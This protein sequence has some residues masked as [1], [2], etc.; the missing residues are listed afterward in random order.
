MK[1][2]P[3]KNRSGITLIEIMIALV[4]I[5]VG[6]LGAM[7]YRYHSALDAR[8]ADVHVG[9]GRVALLLLE[10]WKG[11]AGNEDYDPRT[12][13]G[14]GASDISIY[15]ASKNGY[16]VELTGDPAGTKTFYYAR[17]IRHGL[18]TN[19]DLDGDGNADTSGLRRLEV[20]VTYYGSGGVKDVTLP[21]KMVG[22][23]GFVR[24]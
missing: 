18:Y 5:V 2:K 19:A 16:V 22:V 12:I 8:K 1:S 7:M 17:L 20:R 4:I 21:S 14:V 9:A 10:G 11:A 23:A 24:L 3:R 13:G 15:D 6:V